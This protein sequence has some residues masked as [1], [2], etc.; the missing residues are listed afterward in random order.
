MNSDGPLVLAVPVFNAE[1]FLPATLDSLTAQGS[2]VRWWLQDGGSTDR[3]AEIAQRYARPGDT[4]ISEKDE[5]QTDALN[6]AFHQMGGS[7]VGFLNGDDLLAP[8]TAERVVRYFD[9]HPEIDLIYGSVEWIDETGKVTG[10]H[11]GRI[12]SLAEML[13]IYHVWW[14]ERQWVQPEV[15]FRRSL[16]ERVGNFDTRWHLAF[17]YDYWVRCLR[18]GA[19]FAHISEVIAKF[20]LHGG[21]KST[22]SDKAADEIRAIVRQHLPTASIGSW[23]RRKIEASLAYDEYQLGRSMPSGARPSFFAALLSHPQWLL[24]TAVRR[25]IQSSLA[26]L[27]PFRRRKSQ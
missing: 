1:V 4:V 8:G 9:E 10:S 7:I 16:F 27:L 5:G 20:R 12:D 26:N 13:D 18:A 23:Q 21:Q 2:A 11:R 17:D 15:F 25:R 19:R 6:R 14:R 24:A 3:T 22:A